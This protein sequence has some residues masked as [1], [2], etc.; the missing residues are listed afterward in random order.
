MKNGN[1]RRIRREQIERWLASEDMTVS[2]WCK[3][4][5]IGES[6]FYRW[7]AVF[8]EEEP[9]IFGTSKH[10]GWIEIARQNRKDAMSLAVVDKNTSVPATPSTRCEGQSSYANMPITVA[11][12]GATISIPSG[13]NAADIANVMKAVMG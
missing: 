4:N 12:N 5:H 7:L 6:T 9:E 10:D 1:Q 13:S 2:E 3:R 11:I 8:R